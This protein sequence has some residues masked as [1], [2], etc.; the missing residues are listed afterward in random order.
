MPSSD[1]E[2]IPKVLKLVHLISP[3]SVLDVG[4]GNGRYGFLFREILDWNEKR[5]D[6]EKWE[7][8]IDGIE[9]ERNYITPVHEYI[10][11]HIYIADWL[12]FSPNRYD[13]IFMGDILEHFP[14]G[15]WE[16]AL[17]E[18]TN[19]SKFTIVVSPNWKGSGEQE[20]WNGNKYEKHKVE[21]SPQKVG[22]RCIFA[23]SK[24][25]ICL[26]DNDMTGI[27]DDRRILL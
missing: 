9:V 2:T 12:N 7:I 16:K 11:D 17:W 27:L 24:T 18:A 3:H 4:C 25:F 14:E 22:G 26:F 15:E 20:E 23:N 5:I 10:Y 21:L 19:N 6:K 13:L 1:P 8:L